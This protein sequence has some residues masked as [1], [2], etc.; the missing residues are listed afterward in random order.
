MLILVTGHLGF[1]GSETVR[2][3]EAAGHDVIGY[4]IMEGNDICQFMDVY[5][6]MCAH[7]PDRVL[8]LAAIARFADADRDPML[9]YETN[10]RGTE[11]VAGAARSC[12]IPIVF[13]STGSAIMPLDGY[14]APYD[15]SIPARGNSIYG[16]TKAL[17]EFIV[18]QNTPHIILRY[19]HI[20]G[21]EKRGHGLVGGFIE[22]IERGLQPNLYGGQQT[23]DFTY[24]KDIAR[25][26]VLAL[27]ASWDRWNQTYNIGSGTELTAEDAGKAVCS[28]MGYN[29]EINVITPRTVDPGR[30]CFDISKAQRMLGYEPQFDF[31]SG[32]EDMM[33][34]M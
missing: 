27:E 28:I 7:K 12:S 24:I 34:E 29:G 31:W 25:A 3:L 32:L 33:E 1:V 15:E 6:F 18:A 8:H 21:A 9:A 20:Y 26:N 30:F 5:S 19:A 23:N 4:D 14:D 17:G 22:R 11:H 13:S 10:V 16:V 2:Q